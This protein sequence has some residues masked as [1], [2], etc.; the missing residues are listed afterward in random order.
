MRNTVA[1]RGNPAHS[2]PMLKQA[3]SAGTALTGL[4]GEA[5]PIVSAVLRHVRAKRFALPG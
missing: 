1:A 3:V 4:R 2:M 5:R